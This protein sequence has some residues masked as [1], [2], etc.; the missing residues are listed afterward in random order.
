MHCQ[1]VNVYCVR[2][3][4]A[5][6]SEHLSSLEVITT[7]VGVLYLWLNQVFFF[8]MAR[9]EILGKYSWMNSALFE[10]I[11]KNP[12][13]EDYIKIERFDV[14][15]AL[16]CGENYS[17]YLV[18]ARVEYSDKNGNFSKH[19][20]IKIGLGEQLTRTR[21]VFAKEA[22]LYQEILPTMENILDAAHIPTK[23][24]PKYFYL[25]IYP[26]I[27]CY[28]MMLSCRVHYRFYGGDL[29]QSYLIMEDLQAAN[30]KTIARLQ[31]LNYN[32]LKRCLKSLA[33]WHA[34]SVKILENVSVFANDDQFKW[35]YKRC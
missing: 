1:T 3:L 7:A 27:F 24:A 14:E 2:S 5:L 16:K 33:S 4:N 15:P 20:M 31:G 13:K 34:A 29:K 19:L 21:D 26:H 18:R 9:E 22:Y 23:L 10:T 30:Y 12:H 35:N 32:Q 25:P 11:L 28:R 8:E 6:S 17:S